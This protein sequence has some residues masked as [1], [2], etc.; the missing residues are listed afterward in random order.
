MGTE[1]QHR[2]TIRR[3]GM[4]ALAEGAPRTTTGVREPA[5]LRGAEPNSL[6]AARPP[7][8]NLIRSTIRAISANLAGGALQGGTIGLAGRAARLER[9]GR[10]RTAPPPGCRLKRALRAGA[11]GSSRPAD[12]VHVGVGRPGLLAPNTVGPPTATVCSI[13]V[14]YLIICNLCFLC[15]CSC[16][17]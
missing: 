16:H 9:T 11:S 8:R 17:L 4:V 10:G 15:L 12:H 2:T 5:R 13:C 14:Y 6:A 7:I 3:I 1:K